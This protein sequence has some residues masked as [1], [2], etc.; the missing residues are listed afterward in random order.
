MRVCLMIEGQEN[1]TWGQWC[2]L[3][4]ACEGF[5]FEGLFR[6]DHY[7][8]VLNRP[9][10]GSLDAWTTLAGLAARTRRIRLGTM[11]SPATF[12]HPSLLAK[13][14]V[15]V[16]HISGGRAELGIGAGWHEA[17]HSAYGFSFAPV[18]ERFDVLEEQIE[19][20]HR[21]WSEDQFDFK[22]RHYRLGGLRALPKPLQ[23]P[24]PN[25]I[26]GGK[27]NPRS[28]AIA[29]KWADEYN[30]V[31][32]SSPDDCRRRRAIVEAAWEKENRDPSHLV[33]SL[34]TGC[35]VG[36][37]EADLKRRAGHVMAV[38]G[39]GGSVDELLATMRSE[40]I[41]GTVEEVVDRIKE[42]ESAGVQRVMLQH[43]AHEDVEMVQLIG[44]QVIPAVP[45]A[46]TPRG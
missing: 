41:A 9:D 32:G 3:A 8:S 27:A 34:M 28:A 33:F 15:T 42:F 35:V 25:L 37:D 22:G 29:A 17:E 5:G 13:A 44:E 36:S 46:D 1:V 24:H 14:V 20:V 6:S 12:R 4:D 7:D 19:I 31:Y 18:R 39:E 26:V 43:L 10:R 16:D 30:T 45:S 23:S 40:A 21:S 38:G 11:V 2:A